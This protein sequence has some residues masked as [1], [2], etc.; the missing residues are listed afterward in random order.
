VKNSEE[1]TFQR[2]RTPAQKQ[3]RRDAILTAARALAVRSGVRN[4]TL[5]AVADEGS[6]A[7]T[8]I[9]RYFETRDELCLQITVEEWRD[10][11]NAANAR[12]SGKTAGPAEIADALALS[13]AKQPLLCDLLAQGAANLNNK[14]SARAVRTL[15][16]TV[17]T[18]NNE[19]AARIADALPELGHLLAADLIIVTAM[20]AGAIWLR[21]SPSSA[22]KSVYSNDPEMPVAFLD[23]AET[24]RTLLHTLITGLL[25][26]EDR[27]PRL[28]QQKKNS[29]PRRGR[30]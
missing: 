25:V 11:A 23:F 10:W 19:L 20:M 16:L 24:L 21:A 27:P 29:A 28:L 4:L 5:A 14:V 12:L 17:S 9:L 1:Q 22:L 6:L 26:S 30:G 15:G 18:A 3:Q 2:A 13:I 7:K 8:N